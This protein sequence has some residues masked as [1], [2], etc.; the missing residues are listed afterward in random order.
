MLWFER[1]ILAQSALFLLQSVCQ[2]PI[3]GQNPER[4]DHRHRFT[5]SARRCPMGAYGNGWGPAGSSCAHVRFQSA[6]SQ[7]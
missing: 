6:D 7:C 1:F 4:L 2:N 5:D 3:L